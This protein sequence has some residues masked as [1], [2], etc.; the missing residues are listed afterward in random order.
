MSDT[1][2]NILSQN[3]HMRH[4]TDIGRAKHSKMQ[5]ITIDG[6]NTNGDSE[7]IEQILSHPNLVPFF[8]PESKTE[9]PIAGHINGRFISRR[10]DRMTINDTTKSIQIMDYKTDTNKN[11]F[12]DKYIAQLTEYSK[13]LHEIYPTYQITAYIL[14]LHDFCLEKVL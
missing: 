3:E 13:L 7:I 14:W 5:N 6:H 2:R 4:A 10:I 12:H 1:L 8:G 11:E 9:V